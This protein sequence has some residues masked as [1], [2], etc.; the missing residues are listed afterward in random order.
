[1]RR[2]DKIKEKVR[3]L[4]ML[5]G[6]DSAL[7]IIKK[8]NIAV[9]YLDEK[10]VSKGAYEKFLGTPFIYINTNLCMFELRITST[11]ELGHSI[12][13]PDVDTFKLKKID[14]ISL[15]KY[16]N[17][18]KLFTAEFLLDDDIFYKY[19]GKT[20]SYI[21]KEECVSVELVELKFKNCNLNSSQDIEV[22]KDY[23]SYYSS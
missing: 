4:K 2:G 22:L 20:A 23:Y 6:N 12:L 21:A 19:I 1:M 10:S 17:E 3:R 8:R 5:Y 13:H 7:E 15:I 14:P 9:C 16:E 11:H 18:A